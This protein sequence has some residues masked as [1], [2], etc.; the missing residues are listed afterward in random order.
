MRLETKSTGFVY[1]R[2]W[3][4]HDTETIARICRSNDGGPVR[5]IINGRRKG[6]TGKFVSHKAGLRSMPWE[7]IRGELPALQI[8]EVATGV[9]QL[10][11]QPHRLEINVLQL[12]EPLLYFPD[13]E[14]DVDDEFIRD[15]TSGTS[16]AMAAA[17]PRA[18]IT[19]RGNCRKLIIE[20]KTEDDPRLH[21][22]EY[23]AKLGLAAE[24]Y[25]RLGITFL[26]LERIT[27]LPH[28][29]VER[30][31]A[32]TIDRHTTISLHDHDA[33]RRLYR[34]HGSFQP[35]GSV[36]DALGGGPVGVAKASAMQVRR[37]ISIDL[38]RELCPDTNV[39]L[40]E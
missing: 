27:H 21:D 37:I 30:C 4:L 36:V 34:S 7:S 3:R 14:L 32:I 35:Y 16:F 19:P 1:H 5:Q 8:A 25:R 17:W 18:K 20:I 22:P 39:L 31:R 29:L 38:T 15:L 26:V 28:D 33:L 24:V 12:P 6:R 13:M 40:V 10:L 9:A 2:D 23:G 11:V